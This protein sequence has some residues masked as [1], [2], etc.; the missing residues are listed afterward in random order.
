MN[1]TQ[2]T[3]VIANAADLP[4]AKSNKILNALLETITDSLRQGD[5]LNLVGFGNFGVKTRAARTGR[6]PQ[7]GKAINIPETI[8]P[9]F[10]PG[11]QLKAAV[12]SDANGTKKKVEVTK[13]QLKVVA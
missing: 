12:A 11:K 5:S 3:E 1:K 10:K 4:L 7:T 6:N 9:Y 13:R 8:V 2:L